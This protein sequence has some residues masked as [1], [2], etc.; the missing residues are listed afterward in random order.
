MLA[1]TIE[2]KYYMNRIPKMM[3]KS[4]IISVRI[5]VLNVMFLKGFKFPVTDLK[6]IPVLN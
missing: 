6:L 2:Q 1:S 5:S 3:I 4:S